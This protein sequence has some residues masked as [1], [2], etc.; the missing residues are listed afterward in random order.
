MKDLVTGEITLVST[1]DAGVKGNGTSGLR[2]CPPTVSVAF[3]SYA[4]NLD[5]GDTDTAPDVYVKDLVTGELTL[6]STSDTGVKGNGTSS[7]RRC[8]PTA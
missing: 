3:D 6:V 1:S 8:L 2:R 7:T 4:S 5:P